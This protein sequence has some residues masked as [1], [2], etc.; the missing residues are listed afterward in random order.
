LR[1]DERKNWGQSTLNPNR[2]TP[3]PSNHENWGQSTLIRPGLL[4][5]K[6]R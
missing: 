4:K 1:L 2:Y 5:M 6:K 3:S